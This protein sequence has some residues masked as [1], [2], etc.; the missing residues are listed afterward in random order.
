MTGAAAIAAAAFTLV[1]AA[2]EQPSVD[3]EPVRLEGVHCVAIERSELARLL[4]IEL[5]NLS[6][7]T[8]VA[9]TCARDTA[10]VRVVDDATGHVSDRTVPTD[11]ATPVAAARFV[12]L[13]VAELVRISPASTSPPSSPPSP[14]VIH[15]EAVRT[16]PRQGTGP[17]WRPSEVAVFAATTM[18]F[19]GLE[20]LWGAG[21]R[22]SRAFDG[23][24]VDVSFDGALGEQVSS[25]ARL[26]TM[27]AGAAAAGWAG[28][29]QGGWRVRAGVGARG[30]V[31][32]V[33]GDPL[34]DGL[35]PGSVTG[36]WGGPLVGVGASVVRARFSL[37]LRAEAGYVI[38]PV[39]ASIA[40]VEQVS[41]GGTWVGLQLAVGLR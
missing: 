37:E 21:V 40:G 34:R 38:R 4:S 17:G 7:P 5:R 23:A 1:A 3:A 24:A 22:V 28:W 11:G 18:T 12:A 25:L 13:A 9:V 27:H 26:R 10:Y 20:P 39:V 16:P 41:L 8:S 14:P 29:G 6:T 15:A 19:R 30:G 32:R 36:A 2:S 35:R 31:A 33:A